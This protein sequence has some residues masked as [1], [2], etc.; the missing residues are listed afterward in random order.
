MI[1]IS[2]CF[3]A[4]KLSM[5]TIKSWLTCSVSINVTLFLFVCFCRWNSTQFSNNQQNIHWNVLFVCTNYNSC[6][7]LLCTHN[8][9]LLHH[10]IILLY[11]HVCI[12]WRP[13]AIAAWRLDMGR[14]QAVELQWLVL[15]LVLC[16]VMCCVQSIAN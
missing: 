12:W 11:M 8:V 16:Q 4:Q 13:T 2:W 14:R 5:R 3:G 7:V 15:W 9:Q 6:V 1:S 10:F